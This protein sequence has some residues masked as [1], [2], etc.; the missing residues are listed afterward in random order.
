[1]VFSEFKKDRIDNQYYT[2]VLNAEPITKEKCDESLKTAQKFNVELRAY[3]ENLN[4]EGIAKIRN[5]FNKL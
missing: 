3:M 2:P 5:D 1:M 4:L